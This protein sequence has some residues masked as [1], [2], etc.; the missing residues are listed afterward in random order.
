MTI[1][2]F[3]AA[4]LCAKDKLAIEQWRESCYPGISPCIPSANYHI[5]LH[6]NGETTPDQIELITQLCVS[7]SAIN[8]C[9]QKIGYFSKP[10]IG[11]LH[12][13]DAPQLTKLK[14]Q[15]VKVAKLAN[16]PCKERPFVPHI[17]LFRKLNQPLPA[18]MLP[19][20]FEFTV[21]ELGLYASRQ[22]PNG[23]TYQP[24]KIWPL[25]SGL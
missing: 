25:K 2:T 21:T 17:S 11:F 23:V 1:R 13:D 19:P 16:I 18:A 7:Q 4:A 6:F 12:V 15:V 20:N 10:K 5:T 8:I 22:T 24:L 3:F 14:D 9:I